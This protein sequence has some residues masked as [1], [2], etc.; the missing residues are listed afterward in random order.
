MQSQHGELLSWSIPDPMLQKKLPI[1][2]R[3]CTLGRSSYTWIWSEMFKGAVLKKEAL[4][5]IKPEMQNTVGRDYHQSHFNV[6]EGSPYHNT[7][8]KEVICKDYSTITQT[9]PHVL[10]LSVSTVS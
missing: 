6:A 2:K 7:A 3:L 8:L 5:P 9:R 10:L 1:L 4:K